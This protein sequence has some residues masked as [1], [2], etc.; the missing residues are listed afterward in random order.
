MIKCRSPS[1]AV[2]IK[3]MERI[4]VLATTKMVMRAMRWVM[5]TKNLNTSKTIQMCKASAIK[6]KLIWKSEHRRI[7]TSLMKLTHH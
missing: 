7:W 4:Q 6:S 2:R 1:L 5:K 3:T